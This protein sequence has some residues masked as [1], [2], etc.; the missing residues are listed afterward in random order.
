MS[1]E[2][3]RKAPTREEIAMVERTGEISLKVTLQ[4]AIDAS[5]LD[6]P[7]FTAFKERLD[8]L[9]I[10]MV[11]NIQSTGRVSGISFKMGDQVMKGSA[12][13][14]K[15][16]WANLCK[17][18][19]YEPSRDHEAIRGRKTEPG[20]RYV[21]PI[22]SPELPMGTG[23]GGSTAEHAGVPGSRDEVRRGQQ[24]A[25]A[26]VDRV[27]KE[28]LGRNCEE[29]RERGQELGS[30]IR[31]HQADHAPRG[32]GLENRPGSSVPARDGSGLETGNPQPTRRR[33]TGELL[34]T[35]GA[36]D[37]S[38]RTQR[39]A[40]QPKSPGRTTP[41][42]TVSDLKEW[43]K[44]YANTRRIPGPGFQ[45]GRTRK[46]QSTGESR[47]DRVTREGAARVEVAY[48]RARRS[49]SERVGSLRARLSANV[50]RLFQ[51]AKEL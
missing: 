35:V 25:A 4:E 16:S 38:G 1:Q 51:R 37:G 33:E 40:S 41:E 19:E 34:P 39:R 3:G 43:R 14:K 15:Y 24:A 29:T 49:A 32:P 27:A 2:V 13:G 8:T 47:V 17:E 28:I 36:G 31:G 42:T 45:L 48:R 22:Q 10:E 44:R 18:V 5:K 12:L 11:A 30:G 20:P 26:R 21:G 9:G 6:K 46:V 23:P 7:T 50:G